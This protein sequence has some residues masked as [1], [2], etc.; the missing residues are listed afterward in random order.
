MFC[1]SMMFHDCIKGFSRMVRVSQKI[2]FKFWR[3]FQACFEKITWITY[4]CLKGIEKE[5]SK[6]FQGSFEV[7]SGKCE[8]CLKDLSWMFLEIFRGVF[9]GSLIFLK[10]FKVVWRVVQ[11]SF[12]F[13]AVIAATHAEGGLVLKLVIS[14]KKKIDVNLNENTSSSHRTWKRIHLVGFWKE[15]LYF[16]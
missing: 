12:V 2:V 9:K 14:Y 10:C 11:E 15:S 5:V 7:F 3:E 16:F 8:E 6:L 1:S 4:E 13:M